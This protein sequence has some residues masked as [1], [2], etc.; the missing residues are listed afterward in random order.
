M[1]TL[2]VLMML[3]L[4]A[5]CSAVTPAVL[6]NLPTDQARQLQVYSTQHANPFDLRL[7][8]LETCP[9]LAYLPNV[10]FRSHTTVSYAQWCLRYYT[11]KHDEES[12]LFWR[13]CTCVAQLAKV[14]P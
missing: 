12:T 1:K 7:H 5:G 4:L 9:F 8:S 6:A 13:H 14:Q 3:F 2:I 10:T 11:A